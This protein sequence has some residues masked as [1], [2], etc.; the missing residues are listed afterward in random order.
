MVAVSP[1]PARA[2]IGELDDDRNEVARID[3]SY[4][5]RPVSFSNRK[6]LYAEAMWAELENG[7][8]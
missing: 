6:V 8:S 3:L 7:T 5:A 2:E 4:G 1:T